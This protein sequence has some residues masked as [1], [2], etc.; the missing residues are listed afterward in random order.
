MIIVFAHYIHN[1][2]ETVLAF[3]S[4][5]KVGNDDGLTVLMNTWCDNQ[6]SFHGFHAIKVRYIKRLRH[7]STAL[8]KLYMSQDT[9]I[10]SINV[11]GDLIASQPGSKL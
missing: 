6:E 5:M 3:L 11:K 4:A 9:R 2:L 10:I 8:A 7:S 1:E